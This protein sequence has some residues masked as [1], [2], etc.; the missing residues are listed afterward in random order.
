MNRG[1][2]SDCKYLN[3]EIDEEPCNSCNF[4]PRLGDDWNC[5]LRED[6]WE[7]KEE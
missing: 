7:A 2:C 5:G 6:K 1:L 4:D 3:V